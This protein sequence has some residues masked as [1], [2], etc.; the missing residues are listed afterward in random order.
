MVLCFRATRDQATTLLLKVR[1]HTLSN[2]KIQVTAVRLKITH[3]FTRSC[4]TKC[5]IYVSVCLCLGPVHETV[6]DF[7]RMVWQEQS[8]C[9]VMVTNLVEVGRVSFSFLFSSV[10]CCAVLI[11]KL[12]FFPR[13]HHYYIIFYFLHI[14]TLWHLYIWQYIY[15]VLSACHQMENY[16]KN[17]FIF[18]F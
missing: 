11:E 15:K 18:Y 10:F 14:L 3:F 13:P 12:F 1:H 9:I 8:A 7:W 2:T 4:H 17:I 6:Y 16:I 5:W